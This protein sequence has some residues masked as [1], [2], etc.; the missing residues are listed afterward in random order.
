[1]LP[2]VLLL[3][4]SN[5]FMTA[6]WYGHLRFPQAAL[7]A[8]IVVSWGIA[9]VEYCCQVPANRIG[10][11]AGLSA[12]ELKTIQEVIT[13]IVFVGFA[14]AWLGERP[15]WNTFLGFGLILAGAVCIFAPWRT[16]TP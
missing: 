10:Y 9:L 2:T 15:T 13:L 8:T 1:M 7:W 12:A 4:V 5:L 6:A 3:V 11:R 14:W 16:A